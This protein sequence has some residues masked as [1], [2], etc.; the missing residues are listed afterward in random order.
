MLATEQWR[1]LLPP[2]LSRALSTQSSFSQSR[3]WDIMEG[4]GISSNWDV[5]VSELRPELP[6][7]LRAKLTFLLE[8][9]TKAG[10]QS[11]LR[12]LL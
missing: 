4:V 7:L 12:R 11:F 9:P 3:S 6:Q 8:L 5:P 10:H 2:L 1:Q